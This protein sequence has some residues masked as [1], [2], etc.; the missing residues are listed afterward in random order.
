MNFSSDTVEHFPLSA[1]LEFSSSKHCQM[2][3][4]KKRECNPRQ[5]WAER[6]NLYC[7]ER[8]FIGKDGRMVDEDDDNEKKSRREDD[9]A[10]EGKN[11]GKTG[12][13]DCKALPN[14]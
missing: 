9:R 3:T 8:L 2:E 6:K 14:K 10:T 11:E 12:P 13:N 7:F 5:E 1:L 4:R